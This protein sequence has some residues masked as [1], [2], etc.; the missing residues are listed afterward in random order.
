MTGNRVVVMTSSD[1]VRTSL[2]IALAE[3]DLEGEFAGSTP[4]LFASCARDVPDAV[5]LD[6]DSAEAA[7][8]SGEGDRGSGAARQR[9]GLVDLCRT[10]SASF[11]ASKVA[12]LLLVDGSLATG[13][14]IGAA[15]EAGAR[16]YLFKPLHF[17]DIARTLRAVLATHAPP[18][19]VSDLREEIV[20]AI[21]RG[22]TYDLDPF[23][24]TD[25]L[26]RGG[27]A[28]IFTAHHVDT[29]APVAIKVLSPAFARNRPLL[30]R[31]LSEAQTIQ[32]IDHPYIIDFHSI[33]ER[34]GCYYAVMELV[35]GLS[36]KEY[37]EAEGA[38]DAE[39]A[40]TITACVASALAELH[41]HRIVHRDIKPGNILIADS[42]SSPVKLVDF[43][44]AKSA[45]DRRVT[46]RGTV[47]GTPRYIAPEQAREGGNVDIRA[48]I[49]SLGITLYQMLTGS[50]PF[51]GDDTNELI[52]KH[53]SEHAEAVDL[54]VS[55]IPR[56]VAR[57][58]T[59]MIAKSPDDRFQTP[60]QLL[61]G[62]ELARLGKDPVAAIPGDHEH[63]A[64]RASAA[65]GRRSNGSAPREGKNGS[66]KK[67]G[68]RK[69]KGG[70]KK[71]VRRKVTT[72]R[73]PSASP[74]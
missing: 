1:D 45:R 69:E 72:R 73:N 67:N 27:M 26:G 57:L 64:P 43:G 19:P 24:I 50:V 49:Y 9:D 16:D 56:A 21:R 59:L 74:E 52:A 31:F 15:L 6:I 33:G 11:G 17:E 61:E 42:A 2:A 7:R 39:L 28:T 3:L 63:P 58:V 62:I 46:R 47:H 48:D 70:S 10:L 40:L 4:D 13:D 53:L 25:V 32:Q 36:L 35:N 44:L 60:N 8:G 12:I 37:L 22:E 68:T 66:A 55:D 34:D 29:A 65:A 51:V 23:R 18:A 38:L 54:R 14:R 30:E 5:L 20:W 41:R 71:R